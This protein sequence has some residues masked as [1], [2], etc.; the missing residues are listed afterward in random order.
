MPGNNGTGL[1]L[2][3]VAGLAELHGGRFELKS[4]AGAG[5]EASLIMPKFRV[6]FAATAQAPAKQG[7]NIMP[8]PVRGAAYAACGA[9]VEAGPFLKP[10]CRAGGARLLWMDPAS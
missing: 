6:V 5:T 9:N 2:P 8:F 1:G 7:A 4:R 10:N 3:I